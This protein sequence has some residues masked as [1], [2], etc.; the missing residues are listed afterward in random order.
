MLGLEH[1]GAFSFFIVLNDGPVIFE[2]ICVIVVVLHVLLDLR[3]CPVKFPVDGLDGKL[4]TVFL[5]VVL[6]FYTEVRGV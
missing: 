4:C 5:H 1:L 3:P 2:L 6:A